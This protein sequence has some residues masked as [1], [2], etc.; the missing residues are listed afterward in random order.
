MNPPKLSWE[1]A[2]CF[3]C[4]FKVSGF[5]L[6]NAFCRN[7]RF[8]ILIYS[9]QLKQC[10]CCRWEGCWTICSCQYCRNDFWQ[11][12]DRNIVSVTNPPQGFFDLSNFYS[13]KLISQPPTLRLVWGS[14][15]RLLKKWRWLPRYWTM[16]L[17]KTALCEKTFLNWRPPLLTSSYGAKKNKYNL[18]QATCIFSDFYLK[19]FWHEVVLKYLPL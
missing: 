15:L 7:R 19:Y 10:H 18:Y 13:I 9:C 12:F 8:W 2:A 17:F 11:I 4:C 5:F 3:S 14:R 6:P 16:G 1:K